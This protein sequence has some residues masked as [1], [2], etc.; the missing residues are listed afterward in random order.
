MIPAPTIVLTRLD[1]VPK[2]EEVFWGRDRLFSRRVAALDTIEGDVSLL[3]SDGDAGPVRCRIIG[4]IVS[5]W[6]C[7]CW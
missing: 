3:S 7:W 2:M 1:D 4:V 6:W 5:C